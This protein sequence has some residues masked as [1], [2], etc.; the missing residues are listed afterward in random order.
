MFF[1]SKS[2]LYLFP[3]T[4]ELKLN[5]KASAG[6]VLSVVTILNSPGKKHQTNFL[7]KF[8]GIT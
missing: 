4:A 5:K 3:E 2:D 7:V 1:V 8:A 6:V